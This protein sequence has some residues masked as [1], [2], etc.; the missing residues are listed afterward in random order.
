MQNFSSLACKLRSKKEVTNA[1]L[2][3]EGAHFSTY[4]KCIKITLV[5]SSAATSISWILLFSTSSFTWK[6]PRVKQRFWTK[7]DIK[8]INLTVQFILESLWNSLYKFREICWFLHLTM[9]CN[10]LL[11]K[12]S[13]NGRLKHSGSLKLLFWHYKFFQIWVQVTW[14]LQQVFHNQVFPKLLKWGF[15]E[16]VFLNVF[17]LKIRGIVSLYSQ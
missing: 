15:T 10:M 2:L 17:S 14:M 5:A 4:K 8:S 3:K 13:D 6:T 12:L 16:N 7:L 11:Y 9:K 1:H